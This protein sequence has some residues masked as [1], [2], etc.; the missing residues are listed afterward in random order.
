MNN[1]QDFF[2]TL[3]KAKALGESMLEVC[4]TDTDGSSYR[5]SGARMLISAN[6]EMTGLVTGG[7]LE[8]ELTSIA[9]ELLRTK[10]SQVLE[11]DMR[12]MD[13]NLC[14]FGPGCN[15]RV[16]VRINC[17]HPENNYGVLAQMQ[18][19]F[20]DAVQ[21]LTAI[22]DSGDYAIRCGD[23]LHSQGT[24]PKQVDS[25]LAD[26]Q[27]Q[28]ALLNLEG[29][30]Y[31]LEHIRP[32]K[33]LTLLGASSDAR[34]L[35]VMARQMGF[36]VQLLDER[37]VYITEGQA[38]GLLVSNFEQAAFTVSSSD[39]I[40]IMSHDF[41]RDIKALPIALSSNA[42][43]IGLLGPADRRNR[44][45]AKAELSHD[46]FADRLF[47]PAGLDIGADSSDQI[48]LSVLAEMMAT[49][50]NRSGLPLREKQGS[51]HG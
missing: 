24:L 48:V 43:Y 17:L 50:N 29:R 7:C 3:N 30:D 13:P 20:P 8:G 44:L 5:K 12:T 21:L 15:G 28:P 27:S 6:G 22:D 9:P 4:I 16:R 35:A 10:K 34:L 49:L 25:L 11:Y 46:Q 1:Y 23:A 47:S 19:H 36:Y 45:L 26:A 41:D 38:K 32:A 18:N 51:I 14:V 2:A 40:V 31:L 39:A 42:D 37:D 33:R